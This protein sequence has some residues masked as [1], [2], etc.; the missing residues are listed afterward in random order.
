MQIVLT[1][2]RGLDIRFWTIG[3]RV[4]CFR[5]ETPGLK[6]GTP[7]ARNSDLEIWQSGL[8]KCDVENLDEG[9]TV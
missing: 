8:L 4:R 7:E 6:I 3:L 1:L 9:Q 2:S 5:V